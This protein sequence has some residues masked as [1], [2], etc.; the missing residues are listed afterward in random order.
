MK[1][2]VQRHALAEKAPVG[3]G[4]G[5]SDAARKLTDE[6][7]RQAQLAA[8]MMR[9]RGADPSIVLT[10]T[11]ARCLATAQIM[12]KILGA[13]I[14]I[15]E[16][17]QPN[18]DLSGWLSRLAKKKPFKRPLVIGH[19]DN[20]VPALADLGGFEDKSDIGDLEPGEIRKFKMDKDGGW[21]ERWR[22]QPPTM[23]AEPTGQQPL[24]AGVAKRS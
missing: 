12:S 21:S 3:T 18:E 6:G 4:H 13:P 2:W 23:V 1:L 10:D 15:D 16:S 22:W 17:L 20:L 24:A 5:I 19:H 9:L 8:T 11:T 14:Q 7:V